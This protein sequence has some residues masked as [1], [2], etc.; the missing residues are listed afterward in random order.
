MKLLL[1]SLLAASS[2]MAGEPKSLINAI[3]AV[4]DAREALVADLVDDESKV[5]AE[6]T[7]C[8]SDFSKILKDEK[9]YNAAVKVWLNEMNKTE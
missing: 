2:L 9:T 8:P 1:I 3:N 5:R 6:Y 7:G 4:F